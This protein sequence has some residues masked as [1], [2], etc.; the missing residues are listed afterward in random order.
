MILQILVGK[1]RKNGPG[2]FSLQKLRQMAIYYA[3]DI[4]P[5]NFYALEVHDGFGVQ[6]DP[7]CE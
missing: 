7:R 5:V 4:F 3:K 6:T 1:V 2:S